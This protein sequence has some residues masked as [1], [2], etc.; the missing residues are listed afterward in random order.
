MILLHMFYVDGQSQRTKRD[1]GRER[2]PHM[3]QSQS[4]D[5]REWA[6]EGAV[7]T[8]A[9]RQTVPALLSGRYGRVESEGRHLWSHLL[10]ERRQTGCREMCYT[11]TVQDT[12]SDSG[13]GYCCNYSRSE[14][15]IFATIFLMS[16]ILCLRSWGGD[17]C[18]QCCPQLQFLMTYDICL[19]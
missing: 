1:T 16:L 2:E 14:A 6:G 13:W 10:W 9:P 15:D 8:G 5:L 7:C 12:S 11:D 17:W 3:M 19:I 18:L 4:G